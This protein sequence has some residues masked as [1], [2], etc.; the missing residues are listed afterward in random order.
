MPVEDFDDKVRVFASKTTTR[1]TMVRTALALVGA[2]FVGIRFSPEAQAAAGRPEALAAAGRPEVL[3]TAGSP[4]CDNTCYY[5]LLAACIAGGTSAAVLCAAACAAAETVV[6]ALLCIKCL[7]ATGIALEQCVVKATT[8][9][10]HCQQGTSCVGT[11]SSLQCC[12]SDED[13]VYNGCQPKCSTCQSRS[14]LTLVCKDAC[15]PPTVCAADGNCEC[16]NGGT[17]CSGP[18]CR[19]LQNDPNNCGH[20]GT[21]CAA[22]EMCQ[23]GQCTCPTGQTMCSGQCVD[24]QTDPNNCGSC[25]NACPGGDACSGGTC[26]GCAPGIPC[27]GTCISSTET[28]CGAPGMPLACAPPLNQCCT[29]PCSNIPGKFAYLCFPPDTP[30]PGSAIC[31]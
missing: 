20:C 28:C 27:N 9:C 3:A 13:C 6:G 24:T 19:D 16:P 14:P 15:P 8:E 4:V 17:L 25:G 11:L 10:C 26:S 21:V 12:S 1:R 29:V 22:G 23:T 31:S 30:C 5:P 7:P 2:S 18:A